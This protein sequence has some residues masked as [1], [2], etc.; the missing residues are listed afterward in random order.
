MSPHEHFSTRNLR[1]LMGG[2]LFALWS[3]QCSD[4]GIDANRFACA[5]DADC[6]AGAT[7]LR[8]GTGFECVLSDSG[9]GGGAAAGGTSAGGQS[10][11]GSA[12]G[13]VAGG[14]AG[15]A[16]AGG[17]AGGTAGGGTPSPV[18]AVVFASGEQRIAA[19]TCSSP[20]EIETRDAFD[21]ATPVSAPVSVSLTSIPRTGLKIY[22]GAGCTGPEVSS[23]TIDAGSRAVRFSVRADSANSFTLL[24]ESS[25]LNSATQNLT[26]FE[27]PTQLRLTATPTA[28]LRAGSCFPAVVETRGA[29]GA[30]AVPNDTPV[31]FTTDVVNGALFFSDAMC[32]TGVTQVTVG[33]GN[34]AANLWVK[35]VSGV[36]MSLIATAPFAMANVGISPV[37]IVRRGT[38]RVTGSSQRCP[39]DAPDGGSPIPATVGRSF[40]IT[41]SIA[42]PSTYTPLDIEVRCLP[43]GAEVLCSRD[44]S[45][46]T[47]DALTHF[48][49]VELP[50]GLAVQSA[51]S[52]ACVGPIVLPI[53]VDPSRTFLL[54][55]VIGKR[56]T[57]D[58]DDSVAMRL[59]APTQVALTSSGC[60]SYD[61]QTVQWDG[62]SVTRGLVAPFGIPAGSLTSVVSSLAPS[63]SASTLVLIQPTALALS[64]CSVLARA[65][66]QSPSELRFSRGASRTICGSTA[67]PVVVWERIDFGPRARVWPYTVTLPQPIRTLM[68][69]ITPVDPTRSFVITSS[70]Q[71][72][73]QGSGEIDGA[74][75]EDAVSGAVQTK[76]IAAT[77]VSAS[78]V[79]V[80]RQMSNAAATITFYVVQIDP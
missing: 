32:T 55:S 40:L 28:P 37:P 3:C 33:A 61:V 68:N 46:S 36:P 56:D 60:E 54:K 21:R 2:V 59:V 30:L 41:Q 47:T 31:T 17:E 51:S 44:L 53:A 38:C 79:E 70:Q 5:T 13:G 50:S 57:Y 1:A 12:A 69:P 63:G 76:L 25:S 10:G 8:R 78:S 23:G 42:T 34:S 74:L 9:F 49:V 24:A 62:V 80:T 19:R 16:A 52:S 58:L 66:V 6:G 29:S 18:T 14:E 72:G 11:G 39:I 77:P 20:L 75:E 27:E 48:Q 73:G 71:L 35:P 4:F 26:V 15:G 45:G 43:Q 67:L 64:P 22:L 7:C 65:E